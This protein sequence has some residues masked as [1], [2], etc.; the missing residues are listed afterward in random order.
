MRGN[1]LCGLSGLSV[2]RK[3][4]WKDAAAAT[5]SGTAAAM[6]SAIWPVKQ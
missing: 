4:P 6:R 3:P 5:L 2:T 1:C